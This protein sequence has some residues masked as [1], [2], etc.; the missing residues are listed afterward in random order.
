MKNLRQIA[1]ILVA[2]LLAGACHPAF[3]DLRI[4]VA[5][6]PYP[7]FSSK[8]ASGQWVGWEIDYAQ[9]LCAQIQEKCEITEVAWD[10][11]I[12]ALTAKKIDMIM[13]SMA[14]TPKRKE[15]IAFSDPYYNSPPVLT[16]TK[17]GDMDVSADHLAGKAIGVQVSTIHANYAEK[18]FSSAAIK[19]YQTQ[20][21]VWQDLAAGRLDYA[22]A[23]AIASDAFLKNDSGTCCEFKMR[24]PVDPALM[25][26][27]VGVGL[28]QEDTALLAKLNAGIAALEA[29]GTF[30]KI[31]QKYGLAGLLENPA[32]K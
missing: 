13:S 28:R 6:E 26:P 27:G 23:E 25:G 24:L 8:D 19:T 4:G 30:D 20:D 1:G 9:A 7:P 32:K 15:T 31:S 10:G 16:G 14:I 21:E 18:H 5:A 29:A 2:L 12:P 11:I 22:V 3:A 17:T